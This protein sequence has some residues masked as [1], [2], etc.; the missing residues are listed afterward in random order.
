MVGDESPLAF[1]KLPPSPLELSEK[2]EQLR[3]LEAGMKIGIAVV[4]HAPGGID[5]ADDLAEVRPL[6]IM[7]ADL[8]ACENSV[9]KRRRE[10]E[11]RHGK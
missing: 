8:K 4:D 11:A 9:K 10:K 1:I 2:L 3:A 5:T 6:G 7:A